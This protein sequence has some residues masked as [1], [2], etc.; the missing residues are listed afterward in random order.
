[1]NNLIR[2]NDR[3]D[4]RPGEHDDAVIA[5]MMSYYM[6]TQAKNLK[7][8]GI[9]PS[10]VLI[11]VTTAMID[12]QGGQDAINE[13]EYQNKLLHHIN[14]LVNLLKEEE[15]DFKSNILIQKIKMYSKE[16]NED[17]RNKFNI[18]SLIESTNKQKIL[19]NRRI[20]FI[21]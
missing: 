18:E 5:Y 21:V 13:R 7:H 9:P 1:M 20:N 14:D 12:E 17:T 15:N 6:L 11:N 10:I 16:L 8:Y 2:K 4:H 3:I 19:K